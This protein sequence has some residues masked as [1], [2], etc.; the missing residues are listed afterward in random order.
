VEKNTSIRLSL[1][2]CIGELCKKSQE[3][4]KTVLKECGIPFF[5]DCVNSHNEDV[6]NAS[7][8][9]IQVLKAF[10]NEIAPDHLLLPVSL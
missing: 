5:M 6:V 3:R 1:I 10:S 8:Y 2:R 7:G 4:A 9:I